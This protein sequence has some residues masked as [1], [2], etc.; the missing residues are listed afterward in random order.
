MVTV[1]LVGVFLWSLSRLGV[2]FCCGGGD[3]GVSPHWLIWG[4][5][6]T[7][8]RHQPKHQNRNK[9]E[10]QKP[11]IWGPRG[12]ATPPWTARFAPLL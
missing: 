10:I 1:K 8:P 6:E 4:K 5:G 9:I 12:G 2:G 7:L 11:N 3:S